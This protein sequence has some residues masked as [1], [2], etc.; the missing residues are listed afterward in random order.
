[1]PRFLCLSMIYEQ[2]REMVKH[3]KITQKTGTAIYF[4]DPH[5]L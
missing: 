5:S 2:G 4:D 3:V 1:V